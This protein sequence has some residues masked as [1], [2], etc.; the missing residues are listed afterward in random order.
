MD[1]PARFLSQ[2]GASVTAPVALYPDLFFFASLGDITDPAK[3]TFFER[4]WLNGWFSSAGCFALGVQA[5]SFNPDTLFN[6][7]AGA[8]M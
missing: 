6:L 3:A 8:V 2:P 4:A 7:P 1:L 5:S